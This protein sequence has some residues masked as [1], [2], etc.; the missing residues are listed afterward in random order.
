MRK[1]LFLGRIML[2]S[3]VVLVS[4][5]IVRCDSVQFIVPQSDIGTPIRGGS[6]VNLSSSDLN[7]TVL[8]GQT[9]PLDLVLSNNNLARLG[10]N[11]PG[12]FGILLILD[13]NAA[14]FPG[15]ADATGYLLDSSGNQFGAIQV[16]G[17]SD[18]SCGSLA[19]GLVSFSSGNLEGNN[20]VDTSGVHF[21]ITLP[22]NGY[23]VTN[24][25]L[26]YEPGSI[27]NS[28]QFGTAQQ[29]SE[30]SS[31]VLTL[32]GIGLIARIAKRQL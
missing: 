30:P 26:V 24:A 22:N 5:A 25:E 7:G 17:G 8:S 10:M 3:A 29:L 13:T 32:I 16:A 18:C 14:T 4:P 15:F 31:M 20:S 11:A 12:Q 1:L 23:D 19:V 21:N 27:Y 2:I 6:V 28:V 9:L